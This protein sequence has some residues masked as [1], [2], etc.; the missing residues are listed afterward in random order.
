MSATG[1]I[2]QIT[3]LATNTSF[4]AWATTN[5]FLVVIILAAAFF[6]FAWFMG[7]GAFVALLIS[8]M[9]AYGP[10]IFFPYNSF[11][12]KEPP[13]AALL[14]NAGV[15]AVITF[16]FFVV[17]K[18]VISSDFIYIGLLGRFILSFLGTAFLIALASHVFSIS[19][20]Y[21]FTPAI[22]ALF[23]QEQYF[24]WWFSGP[25]IGLLFF[26]R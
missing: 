5:D 18:R 15:Y 16:V 17:L 26:A 7:R 14:A 19:S 8:L 23:A 13:M 6:L 2:A 3:N 9:A 1:T 21:Q 10:F 22:S 25:A 24:F 11:L 4:S 12:P 20:I